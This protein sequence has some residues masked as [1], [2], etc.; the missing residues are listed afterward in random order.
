MLYAWGGIYWCVGGCV[1]AHR[2]LPRIDTIVHTSQV[3]VL[4]GSFVPI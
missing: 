2:G 1:L 4:N 3:R